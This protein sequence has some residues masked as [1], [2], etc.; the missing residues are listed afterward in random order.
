MQNPHSLSI[1]YRS[2]GLSTYLVSSIQPIRTADYIVDR[3]A[4]QCHQHYLVW[5]FKVVDVGNNS[6]LT[7]WT[8]KWKS[9]YRSHLCW[10]A[11]GENRSR[12]GKSLQ[13]LW[14]FSRPRM[15]Q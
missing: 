8:S 13:R 14:I 12:P 1:L 6:T 15:D 5:S 10:R 2:N 7:R 3:P 11:G 4:G 9:A